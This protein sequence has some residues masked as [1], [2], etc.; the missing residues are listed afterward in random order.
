MSCRGRFGALTKLGGEVDIVPQK[1]IKG[2]V[3]LSAWPKTSK[4]SLLGLDK[5]R[6]QLHVPELLKGLGRV[7]VLPDL[8]ALGTTLGQ[9]K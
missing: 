4:G 2:F 7:H 5:R 1:E 8:T 9:G 6:D 3:G